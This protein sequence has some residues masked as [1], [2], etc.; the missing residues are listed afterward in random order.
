[1]IKKLMMFF[2]CLFLYLG[3]ATAQTHVTGVVVSSEDGEPI[4]GATVKVEGSNQGVVTDNTGHFTITVPSSNS[5]LEFSYVGMTSKT[6]RAS[7]NMNVSLDPEDSLLDE[8]MVVAFGTAKRSAYT[9]SAKVIDATDLQKTQVTSVTNALAGAVAGVQ[10]TSSNGAPDA[11]STI[12]IRGF[13]SLNAGKDPLIIVDGAPYTSPLSTIN[14]SDVESMTVLKDAASNALYGAR[15]ANGVILITTKQAKK[16]KDATVV[17]DAKYGWNTRALRQYDVITDP[18]Q[19]YE[20]QYTSVYNKLI[21]DGASPDEAWKGASQSLTGDMAGGGLGY[22]IWTWP[23]GQMLVGQNGR[24]NPNATLGR[25]VT[26]RGEDFWVTPDDWM[27]EG[28]RT[29]Q[30]Q[31]Y[32]LSVSAANDKSTFFASVGYLDNEGITAASDY[33]RL[34]GRLRADYQAKKW[35]KVGGNLSFSHFDSNSLENN[36]SST[37]TGNVWAFASQMA[38]I[39]PAWVRNAD[40]S[41]KVDADGITMMDY[42]NGMNA[43]FGRPFISDA[44]PLLDNQLNTRNTEGNTASGNGFM[45]IEFIDGL[46]LTINGTYNLYDRRITT[47][48]NPYYGQFDSTGGTV[49]KTHR[50][51]YN[52]NLLQQLNYST[53]FS[54]VHNFS[55]MLGHEYYRSAAYYLY[56]SKSGMF[57]QK[58]KELGGAVND[59]K[60][61]YSEKDEYNVEGFFGR[62]LYDYDNKYYLQASLRRDA[63]SR[64][65]PDHRWGTFWSAGA[66]WMINKENFF[67]VDWV[68]ELKMKASIGSQGNDNIDPYRYVDQYRIVNSNTN[69]GAYFQSKG[70]ENITWE[71]NTNFNVGLEFGVCKKLTGSIDYYYR[72]TTDLLFSFRPPISIGYASYFRNIGD[73]YN[74]GVELELNYNA[75]NT[76]NVK[77][78]VNFN[79]ASVKNRLTKLDDELKTNYTFD[80]DGNVYYGYTSGSFMIAEDISMYT[81]RYKEYAGVGENGESLW[82]KNIYETDDNGNTIYYDKNNNVVAD[83][84]TFDGVAHEKV[85]GRET[86][87]TW[88]SADYYVTK[89]TSIAPFFGGLGTTLQAYGVDFSINTSFQLGGYQYDGTYQQFMSSPTSQNAGYNFHK[90]MLNAWSLENNGSNIP[91]VVFDDTYSAGGS[92]RF[93]TSSSYFNIENINLGYTIPASI[94]RK[95]QIQ[96]LRIYLACE[97]VFYFSKRKGFDPRQSYSSTTNATYYSPM[98]TFSVGLN[99]TF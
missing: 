71:T 33:Q 17:L 16:G 26:Y 43:G 75:I 2:A 64:F 21:N 60:S 87:D 95:A 72:K 67:D 41:K 58:N 27:E 3:Q 34:T 23:E 38:P 80:K 40:G 1:M 85:I 32:N 18:A 20:M 14:P 13:S 66:A 98:R 63:S 83:L 79:I 97:N 68:D 69:K 88:A 4:V 54:D 6:L 76:R 70:N 31:E 45:D 93:L 44:N 52:Y 11:S 92:T 53:R 39:Y 36:G 62:L 19:Y 15:G 46:K 30:R 7:S 86:T 29:G 56:A 48:L 55:A 57:D 59:N 35:L 74:T 61:A 42:G 65:H 49:E 47:V 94:T 28:T 12:R 82:Y 96:A 10:L 90:D 37:S 78:D 89:K 24:L 9:G 50:R 91:R 77:W 99:V 51:N 22:N 25:K 81:W 73:L 5:R 8:V 84:N